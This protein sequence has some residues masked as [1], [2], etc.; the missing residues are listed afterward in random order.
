MG[1][2]ELHL[3]SPQNNAK[4]SSI[5]DCRYALGTG[6]GSIVRRDA[7]QHV[8]KHMFW[9]EKQPP[10]DFTSVKESGSA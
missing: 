2:C 1:Q 9:L 3:F 4:I 10:K 7:P 6:A 8:R 5:I